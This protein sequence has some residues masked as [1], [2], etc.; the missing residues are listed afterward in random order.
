MIITVAPDSFKSYLTSIQATNIISLALKA[1][2]HIDTVYSLPVSDGGEGSLEVFCYY[3]QCEIHSKECID[4]LGNKLSFPYAICPDKRIGFLESAKIIGYELMPQPLDNPKIA[5]SFGLGKALKDLFDNYPHYVW[6][7]SLGGTATIDGGKDALGG[8]GLDLQNSK[9]EKLKPGGGTLVDLCSIGPQ[10]K[11]SDLSKH[12]V[13]MVCDVKNPLLG[14]NGATRVYG[15][16]KGVRTNEI[17]MF[18]AGFINLA[19]VLKKTSGSFVDQPAYGAAGGIPATFNNLFKWPL[20]NGSNFFASISQLENKIKI[21]DLVITGE[22][23]LD[24]QTFNG[25]LVDKIMKLTSKHNI[26]LLIVAGTGDKDL[27][28]L[29]QGIE[30]ELL[31]PP[32]SKLPK[33]KA[34][35]K[36]ELLAK[37][38]KKLNS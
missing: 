21:S 12:Q 6:Y 16:Q 32:G 20:I 15:P 9:G 27:P 3:N 13:K 36:E 35:V 34:Q 2:K 11:I 18:E 22:G 30:I 38:A 19:K 24:S 29:P 31:K 23:K 10:S 37:I 1:N 8:L 5:S 28:E 17:N 25:K 33:N 14:T 26:K 7:L 4:P